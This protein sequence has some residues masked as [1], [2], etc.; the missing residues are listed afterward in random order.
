VQASRPPQPRRGQ[1]EDR[2]IKEALQT[3]QYAD[4]D[5]Q[6]RHVTEIV[7]Q[8]V[9]FLGDGKSLSETEPEQGRVDDSVASDPSPF[10]EVPW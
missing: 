3:R 6:Q 9:L 8:R 4:K 10:D 5:G 7:A 2:T 1:P